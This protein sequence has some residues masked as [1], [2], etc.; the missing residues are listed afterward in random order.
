MMAAEERITRAQSRL[1]AAGGRHIG[2][3]ISWNTEL[4][5]V[6]RETAR[7]VF[8]TEGLGHLVSSIE[9]AT[10]LSRAASEV[11]KK[12]GLLIRPFGKPKGDTLAAF[13]VYLQKPRDGES[14]DEH[15]CGAR[16][17]IDSA[18]NE[19]VALPPE[20][21]DAID[22]ALSLAAAVATHANHLLSHCETKDLSAALV[23]T[24]KALK[25]VPLRD[26]G[27][28]YLLPPASSD[29]W[30]RLK[31]RLEAIGVRPIRIEMHDAPDNVAVAKSAAQSAL[32]SDLADLVTDLERAE[33]DGM[34]KDALERRIETCKELLAK[35]DLFRGVLEG[36]ADEISRRAEELR[37]RFQRELSG[38][39]D[40]SFAVPIADD[41]TGPS[42]RKN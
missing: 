19:A 24:A 15:V 38:A 14:G 31:P 37:R 28:F 26:R 17:R 21:G 27:G 3:L 6:S 13:A 42:T 40:V 20:G 25:G 41:T 1:K 34:R 22:E 36:K 2:D 39:G 18:T 5:D 23:A 35:A 10:A 16:V 4:I 11:G 7:T 32:E 30:S 8:A 9:P 33:C 29:A 12:P